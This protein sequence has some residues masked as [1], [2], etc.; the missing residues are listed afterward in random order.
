MRHIFR[1]C[2]E[3]SANSARVPPGTW[4]L[5]SKPIWYDPTITN[6]PLEIFEAY[7][8]R[9]GNNLPAQWVLLH[10]KT[11]FAL[12]NRQPFRR[13]Q[14]APTP[15]CP[16]PGSSDLGLV[17]DVLAKAWRAS[18]RVAEIELCGLFWHARSTNGLFYCVDYSLKY[19]VLQ[20]RPEWHRNAWKRMEPHLFVSM[21]T[22]LRCVEKVGQSDRLPRNLVVCR[23][24]E[25]TI[26]P[27]WCLKHG[28]PT[29]VWITNRG[30]KVWR[31]YPGWAG[32]C[33]Q[34]LHFGIY[35]LKG[36]CQH[37]FILK[38]LEGPPILR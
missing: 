16:F 15:L 7:L 31:E 26:H 33:D 23:D 27:L 14:F 37:S 12:A 18:K 30:R 21:V 34:I 25:S 32:L 6:R 9:W 24:C 10:G 36:D 28:Y 38:D 13:G 3:R 19:R 5:A 1:K 8:I 22:S 35:A 20:W 11:W 29:K 17:W 2:I 4:K